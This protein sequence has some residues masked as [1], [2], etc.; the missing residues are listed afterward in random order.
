MEEVKYN[1]RTAN[2]KGS[3]VLALHETHIR[4]KYENLKFK[5]P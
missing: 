1:L 5:I 2:K 4:K 3:E